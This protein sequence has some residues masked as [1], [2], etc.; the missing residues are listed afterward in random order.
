VEFFVDGVEGEDCGEGE[1]QC[2]LEEEVW[3]AEEGLVDV[4]GRGGRGDFWTP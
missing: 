1:P 2:E 4:E 3:V